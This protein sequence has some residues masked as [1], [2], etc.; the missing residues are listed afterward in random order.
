[1]RLKRLRVSQFRNIAFAEL[2]FSGSRVFLF[3]EN[4]QGKTNL[5]EAA[6]L[7][8]ALRSFRTRELGGLVRHGEKFAQAAFELEHEREGETN[9]LLSLGA[10]GTKRVEIGAGTPVAKMR[11]F[12]GRFPAVIFASEDVSVLRGSPSLRRRRFDMTFSAANAAYLESLQ[13]YCRALDA[14]NRLLKTDADASAEFA[15]FEKVLAENG[16]EIVRA[17]ERGI[18]E[19]A[20]RFSEI[21]SRIFARD[22]PAELIYAP[23]RRESDV[24]A[25]QAFFERSR[26]TDRIFHATQKGPH[27]DDFRFRLGGHDAAEFASEGQQR[28]LALALGLAQL[29]LLRERTGIAPIVLAD[30]VLSELDPVRKANFWREI[31]SDLQVIAT[32]TQLPED[33][34]KWEVFNVRN[35]SYFR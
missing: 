16:A 8:T 15:A 32:G 9:I 25:W 20:V 19:I 27:R 28:G 23:S 26:R 21:A 12:V 6:S 1:M 11:D 33:A 7:L 35:G 10:S 13:R 4:A 17:R 29:S 30:D 31:G 34:E 18:A 5:L 24:P 3:G 2:S 22:I 14:R